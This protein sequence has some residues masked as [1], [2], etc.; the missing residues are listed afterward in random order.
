MGQWINLTILGFKV[1]RFVF[2]CLGSRVWVLQR[3]VEGEGRLRELSVSGSGFR[4]RILWIRICGLWF[5][6]RGF[7]PSVQKF[8]VR[9]LGLRVSG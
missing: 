9:D 7:E 2:E 6:V 3:G 4:V 1:Q 5:R 8:G